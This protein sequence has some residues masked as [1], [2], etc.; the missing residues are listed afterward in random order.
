MSKSIG[1]LA[2]S[3][4][5][6]AVL[7]LT[8]RS[9]STQVQVL[10]AFVRLQASTP[11]NVQTG[12]SNISGTMIAGQFVGGGGGITALNATNLSSGTVP[13]ARLSANVPFL[14]ASNTFSNSLNVFSGTV[15]TTGFQLG[16]VAV[17]GRIL[18]SDASGVGTWQP[19]SLSGLTASGDLSG[20]YPAPTVDGL[21]GR[22]V[23]ST[24]PTSSQVLAWTGSAWAPT[25][26]GL[27]LP[28]S[29]SVSS[30]GALI[31]L[32]NTGTSYGLSASATGTSGRGVY[33]HA[34]S[35]T[36][37]AYGGYFETESTTGI[38]VF[39]F[40]DAGTGQ[41]FG[42]RGETDSSSGRAV[43]GSAN[44]LTGS[45]YGGNF[46]NL[47]SSGIAVYGK[48]TSQ[49]GTTY[50][51]YF[52]S[53]G[54]TGRG[55]YAIN[56]STS[57]TNYGVYGVSNSIDGYG[58]LGYTPATSGN[59]IGVGAQSDSPSG[60]G[61]LG[62]ASTSTGINVG[63]FFTTNSGSGYGVYARNTANN[64]G[65]FAEGDIGCSGSKFFV[66]DDP[67]DPDNKFLNHA[68]AEGPE[69]LN[70]YRGNTV[71]DS[72]GEA[73]VQLPDYFELINKDPSYQLTCVGGQANVYVA[74]EVSQ[75][76]FKIAGGRQGLKVSWQV[77]GVRNDRWERAHPRPVEE[78]KKGPQRGHY[79]SPELYG[80][81]RERAIVY[82]P[83]DSGTTSRP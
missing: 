19:L 75:N 32:I 46:Q 6:V 12:H 62:V 73:W 39:G 80:L 30:S 23:A 13:D 74:Q 42:V 20:T 40:A 69:P 71:L 61:V 59:C 67:L 65:V 64:Y 5:A 4:A 35:T 52:E 68:C 29:A 28:F 66:I 24:A 79:L 55:V 82:R 3:L 17:A 45:T 31:S 25:N 54:P 53:S 10:P 16:T 51:G 41:N 9:G 50:G 1:Y 81:P 56:H 60:Y 27:D 57:G 34:S 49:T 26:D 72:R 36:G 11:G 18:T 63:G 70:V 77:T 7:V 37:T 8:T 83:G 22:S 78:D 47:S 76:R 33:G 38:G 58:L 43:Y 48:E 21:Q 44:S 2:M 14:N 15:R